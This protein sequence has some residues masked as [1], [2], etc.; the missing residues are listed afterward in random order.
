MKF[1]VLFA[2][3]LALAASLLFPGTQSRAEPTATTVETCAV[4]SY[5]PWTGFTTA[6]NLTGPQTGQEFSAYS[7]GPSEEQT[8]ILWVGEWP[9]VSPVEYNVRW[10]DAQITWSD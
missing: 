5:D 3:I 4:R 6:Q 10:D 2:L 7:D 9:T 1:P 8:Q